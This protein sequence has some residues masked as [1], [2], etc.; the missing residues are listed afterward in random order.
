V[1]LTGVCRVEVNKRFADSNSKDRAVGKGV[2][3]LPTQVT[4]R[5]TERTPADLAAKDLLS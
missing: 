1:H 5:S 4:I 3:G 2:S